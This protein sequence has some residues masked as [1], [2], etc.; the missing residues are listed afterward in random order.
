MHVDETNCWQQ[1]V[2]KKAYTSSWFC[3]TIA[4]LLSP[5]YAWAITE[6]SYAEIPDAAR[7]ERVEDVQGK[8]VKSRELTVRRESDRKIRSVVEQ[9]KRNWKKFHSFFMCQVS[10]LK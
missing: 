8:P 7:I 2:V 3:P 5:T 4:V 9:K 10:I 1:N 6:Q